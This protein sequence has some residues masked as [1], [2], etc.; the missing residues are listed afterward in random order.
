MKEALK[1]MRQFLKNNYLLFVCLSVDIVL[2]I[3]HLFFGKE[4]S[5]VNFDREMNIPTVWAAF[6]CLLAGYFWFS[7][8]RSLKND[9]IQKSSQRIFVCLGLAVFLYIALDEVLQWHEFL[10]D[11]L[12]LY[13]KSINLGEMF[14]HNNPAFAW[15][16]IFCPLLLFLGLFLLWGAWRFL[17]RKIFWQIVAATSLFVIGSYGIEILGTLNFNEVWQGIPYWY[18]VTAEEFLELLS[19]SL[20]IGIF[21]KQFQKAKLK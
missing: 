13:L 1:S 5:L 17:P 19:V 10:G 9:K 2:L 11:H 4:F 8:H 15:L 21:Y 20:L 14:W 6:Q 16:I 18:L 7:W 12:G 3:L